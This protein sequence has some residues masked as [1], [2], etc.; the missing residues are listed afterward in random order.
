MKKMSLWLS[1][2]GLLIGFALSPASVSAETVTNPQGTSSISSEN[3]E[4]TTTE[5][6]DS[7]LN[8][9]TQ[10]TESSKEDVIEKKES[11]GIV[12]PDLTISNVS[13]DFATKVISGKSAPS[14][15]IYV[16][17]VHDPN[18]TA[19]P[20]ATAIADSKGNFS[21]NHVFETGQKIS[22][23]AQL[24]SVLGE[25]TTFIIPN[26]S[27]LAISNLSYDPSTKT[28]SGKT[29]AGA[30]VYATLSTNK[31]QRADAL[32]TADKDGNF[33]FADQFSPGQEVR[34]VANLDGA[35][36][37]EISFVIPS[38]LPALTLSDLSY[39]HETGILSGKTA[40][41]AAVG[42]TLPATMGQVR[43]MSDENGYFS[44]KED[45]LPGT[46]LNIT[47]FL[48]EESS[49]TIVFT[50]PEKATSKTTTSSK[51]IGKTKKNLPETGE[52][53]GF[54]FT[55]L[56]LLTVLSTAFIYKKI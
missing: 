22:L 17:I 25:S 13:Y 46:V 45:F 18:G 31:G 19:E 23:T 14:A 12:N 50:I 5:Q 9:P 32:T 53:T 35:T 42:L 33:S 26:Q 48:G 2:S 47:A 24:N 15:T 28:V 54:A 44:Y 27:P 34:F 55:I 37:E 1:L 38:K 30:N 36:G 56:G 49:E 51:P 11:I 21:I 3:S 29:A 41:N 4:S 7:V 16:T 52:N 8:T 43:V 39:D 6:T 40:P 20:S 10:T